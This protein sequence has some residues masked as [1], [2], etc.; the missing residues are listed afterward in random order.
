MS[1]WD[2]LKLCN[3]LVLWGLSVSWD[4]RRLSDL[5]ADRQDIATECK[6]SAPRE[7]IGKWSSC[8]VA[9]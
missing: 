5:A 9:R 3:I 7:D 8:A 2:I 1:R 6:I 4:I